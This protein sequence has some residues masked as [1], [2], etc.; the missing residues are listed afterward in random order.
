MV[1]RRGVSANIR[2]ATV[3]KN[4][5]AYASYETADYSSGRTGTPPPLPPVVARTENKA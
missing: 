3:V 1:N 4:G 2:A 5:V